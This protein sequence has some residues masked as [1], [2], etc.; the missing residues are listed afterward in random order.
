MTNPL[1]YLH[2]ALWQKL[3][4][5][6]KEYLDISDVRFCLPCARGF[7]FSR[8]TT[9][10]DVTG[11]LQSLGAINYIDG[12]TIYINKPSDDLIKRLT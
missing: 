12:D 8:D 4:K 5:D 11:M 9:V 7:R 10:W 1:E 2:V 3:S 6:K